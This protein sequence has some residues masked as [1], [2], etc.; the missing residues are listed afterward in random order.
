MSY[1]YLY[2]NRNLFLSPSSSASHDTVPVKRLSRGQRKVL[3]KQNSIFLAKK[4][5]R[6]SFLER[7]RLFDKTMLRRKELAEVKSQIRE[8]LLIAH[9]QCQVL[10][11]KEAKRYVFLPD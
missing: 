4:K 8:M 10:Q 3:A 9:I 7:A 11:R 1:H 5:S 2:S 6:W